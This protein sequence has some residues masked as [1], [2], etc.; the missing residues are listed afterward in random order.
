MD[1]ELMVVTILLL[2]TVYYEDNDVNISFTVGINKQS[3]LA[4]NVYGGL[5]SFRS[6]CYVHGRNYFL[7]IFQDYK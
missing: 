4:N 3:N 1:K 2:S 7:L 5:S 6:L